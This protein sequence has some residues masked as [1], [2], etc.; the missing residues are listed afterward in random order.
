M[1]TPLL[2]IDLKKVEENARLI[3][4]RCQR[5][6]LGLVG[7]VKGCFGNPLVAKAMETGGA[8]TLADS[9]VITLKRLADAGFLGLTM[10]KQPT[11]GEAEAV[12]K[13][14]ARSFISDKII[15]PYL[16]EAAKAANREYEVAIMVETGGLGEGV[17]TDGVND[18]AVEVLQFRSLRLTGLVT[19]LCPLAEGAREGG[20]QAKGVELSEDGLKILVEKAREI[21][22]KFHLKLDFISGGNSS[23]WT[24]IE[25]ERVPSGI[26]QVRMGEAIL[27]GQETL[28]FKPIAGARL[29]AF[30]ISAEVLEVYEKRRQGVLFKQAILSLGKQHIGGGI[31]K[32]QFNGEILH[33]R[34]DHLVIDVSRMDEPTRP[35]D[36]LKFIPGYYALSA[37]FASPLVSKDYF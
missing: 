16:N 3:A 2:S 19:N 13:Y 22:D 7:V 8:I 17:S 18:L 5:A 15:L 14:S 29:D 12:V 28:D 20:D 11:R 26:N 32:P 35:G 23:L 34:A 1:E 6:G 36:V 31:L 30:T 10:L 33:T 24:L 4:G 37:A 21:E 25:Q 9:Q 27:L